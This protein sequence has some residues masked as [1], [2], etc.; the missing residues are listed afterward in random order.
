MAILSET[1]IPVLSE[2]FLALGVA[3]EATPVGLI[4][5]AIAAIG[6]AAFFLYSHWSTIKGWWSSL[7][8]GM[9]DDTE[10][11]ADRIEGAKK[12][13]SEPVR[14]PSQPKPVSAA[15]S[16]ANAN[17]TAWQ[18]ALDTE[19]KYGIP[20]TVSYAQ[21]MLES[22][23][24]KHMPTGSNNPFG[25]KANKSQLA[26]GQFVEAM[27]TE[28]ENGKDVRKLQK[29]AK[30]DSL[31]DAFEAHAK[32]LA[33]SKYYAKA[34]AVE[35]DP[36]KFAD[37]LTGVYATDPKYGEKLKKLMHGDKP[38]LPSA[39]TAQALAQA[40]ISAPIPV[41]VTNGQ[42]A[43]INNNSSASSNVSSTETNIAQLHVHSAAN[44]APG[45]A[46]DI[47]QNLAR[48]NFVTQSNSGPT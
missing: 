38:A 9:A 19:Q 34:R 23:G 5:T 21:F 1:A 13:M 3:I 2:A 16:G 20:A 14:G 29:F 6:A 40:T 24:G 27:T 43:A 28:H 36:D 22:G 12:K 7:F 31:G 25:I 47:K 45:I 4:L 41:T 8:G 30:F 39:G 46:G 10:K 32:L 48:D 17:A 37:A 42:Q 33:T 18:A 44:N 35:N 26:S 11:A 15:G